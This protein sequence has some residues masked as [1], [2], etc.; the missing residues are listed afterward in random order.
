VERE[1]FNESF[2]ALPCVPAHY[3]AIITW[4][5]AYPAYLTA[6]YCGGG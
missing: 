4:R 3:S 1:T 6:F 5:Y 2:H